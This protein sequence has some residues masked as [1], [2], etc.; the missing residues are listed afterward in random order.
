[1]RN[2]FALWQTGPMTA[3]SDTNLADA[4]LLRAALDALPDAYILSDTGGTIRFWNRVAERIFGFTREEAVGQGLNLLIPE[5]FRPAHD[6]GFSRAV[7]T[8]TLRTGTRV[9]RTRSRH[10][11]EGRKLYVDFTFALVKDSD[12]RVQAVQAL[13]RD[14]TE[15]HLQQQ[16][17][18]Q[19]KPT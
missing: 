9:L 13:A 18:H 3:W 6:A 7:E 2:D 10:K 16:A 15:A 4:G 19:A 1:M 14:A 8:G 11:E 12:G 17:A 5:R